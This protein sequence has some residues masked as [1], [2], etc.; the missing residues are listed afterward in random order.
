MKVLLKIGYN[1]ILLIII[2]IAVILIVPILPFTGNIETKV[3]LSGSMEPAIK[4]GSVIVLRPVEKYNIGDIVTFGKDTRDNIPTTHRIID[5]RIQGG[6]TYFKTKGDANSDPDAREIT[7]S[8]IQGKMLFSI[9]YLGYLIDFAKLPMGF[10]LLIV[11]P[12]GI[13]VFD[14]V[15]KIYREVVLMQRKKKKDSSV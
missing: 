7:E 13:V 10:V 11:V 6:V 8:D 9:P 3:V 12:G 1:I 15:R 5:E 14:E 2:S 4:V